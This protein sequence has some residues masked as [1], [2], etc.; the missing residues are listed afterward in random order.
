MKALLK[1][2]FLSPFGRKIV[3]EAYVSTSRTTK[4]IDSSKHMKKA[5][6]QLSLKVAVPEPTIVHECGDFF[7][8]I[9]AASQC[10]IL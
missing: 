1:D 8:S 4:P 9:W 5:D 6:S 3:A 10:F 7:F 2:L